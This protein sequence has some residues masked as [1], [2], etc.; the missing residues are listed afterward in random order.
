M[1]GLSSGVEYIFQV[2]SGHVASVGLILGLNVGI[3]SFSGLNDG[4]ESA[5]ALP[6]GVGLDCCCRVDY[7]LNCWCRVNSRLWLP[8]PSR[9]WALTAGAGSVTGFE[10][11]ILM[12]GNLVIETEMIVSCVRQ[13]WASRKTL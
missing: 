6:T 10:D 5:P 12:L 8:V 2:H 9:L 3:G 11:G 4:V 1:S 13:Y 7:G